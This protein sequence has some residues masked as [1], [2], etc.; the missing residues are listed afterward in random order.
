MPFILRFKHPKGHLG[1]IGLL[2]YDFLNRSK[3]H[4]DHK[5]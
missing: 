4:H 2:Y 5:R 1:Y 3:I